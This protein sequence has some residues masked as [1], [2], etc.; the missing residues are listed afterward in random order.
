M[1]ILFE[2]L[3]RDAGNYKS[4]GHVIFCNANNISADVVKTRITGVLIDHAYFVA[5]QAGVPD[6][7][8]T[9]YIEELDHGW[10]EFYSCE[11]TLESPDDKKN[12]EIEEFIGDL[13]IVSAAS[14]YMVG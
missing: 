14:S 1:N 7:R 9:E 11:P 6:L 2:Y 8:F 12:R 3:Y 5:S 4:W 13:R 10:H